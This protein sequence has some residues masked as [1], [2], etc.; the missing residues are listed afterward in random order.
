MTPL[1]SLPCSS[2]TRLSIEPAQSLAI[3]FQRAAETGT[4]PIRI[5]YSSEPMTAAVTS[6][7]AIC[8]LITE[9]LRT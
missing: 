8:R 5:V 9:P 3:A 1:A 4:M 7:L 6:P 2:S